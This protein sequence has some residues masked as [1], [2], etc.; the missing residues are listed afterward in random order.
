MN[1]VVHF[2]IQAD[3]L[4]RAQ[5]FYE[6]AFGWTFQQM[7]PEYGN[8][9]VITTGPGPDEMAEGVKMEDLGINGGMMKRNAPLPADGM[10][11]NAFTSVMG[12]GDIESI[13]PKIEAA[14]G[15]PQTDLMDVPNVGKIRYYKDTEGNLFGIIQP[16]MR[17]A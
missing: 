1:R 13:M 5:K 3:D 12:V 10:S 14:G 7:G 9:R 6:T 15:K 4:D 17:A 2:E 8:Y 11:P 16:T